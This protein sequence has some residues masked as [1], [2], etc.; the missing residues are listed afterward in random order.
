MGE[1]AVSRPEPGTCT[2]PPKGWYCT[3]DDGHEGQCPALHNLP[4]CTGE[5]GKVC[6]APACPVHD[7][8]GAVLGYMVVAKRPDHSRP[9]EFRYESVGSIWHIME[10]C[11]N[12]QAYCEMAAERRGDKV[13]YQIVSVKKA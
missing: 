5:L 10:P 3:L 1:V 7:P 11:E 12:H 13:E 9:G 4:V 6:K 2:R 8:N